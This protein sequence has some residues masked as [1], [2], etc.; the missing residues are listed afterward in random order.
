MV[1]VIGMGYRSIADRPRRPQ[2]QPRR[3]PAASSSAS[4]ASSASSTQGLLGSMLAPR[5]RA[6]I[7]C[8]DAEV[9]AK[10]ALTKLSRRTKVLV[11]GE[12]EGISF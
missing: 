7:R 11:Y 4:T 10:I 1:V 3:S 8:E 5:R 12:K 9:P 2:E 6:Y